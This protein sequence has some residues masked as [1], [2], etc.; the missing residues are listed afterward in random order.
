LDS[1]QLLLVL[2]SPL[3]AFSP[4]TFEAQ[5][6]YHM[7]ESSRSAEHFLA[8]GL[9]SLSHGP[10]QSIHLSLGQESVTLLGSNP[11]S[12]GHPELRLSAQWT[13]PEW[14]ALIPDL[15]ARCIFAPLP[16]FL[17]GQL[18]NGRVGWQRHDHKGSLRHLT[19][20]GTQEVPHW[21]FLEA[22]FGGSQ[23][24]S[25]GLCLRPSGG[26]RATVGPAPPWPT[27]G[28]PQRGYPW[29][30]DFRVVVD[31]D[32]PLIFRGKYHLER[33]DSQL[34]QC[35]LCLDEQGASPGVIIPVQAGVTLEPIVNVG[36]AGLYAVVSADAL[37]TDLSG[38]RVVRDPALLELAQ[39]LRAQAQ[40][41]LQ[42]LI[43]S[44]QVLPVRTLHYRPRR[45]LGWLAVCAIFESWALGGFAAVL[46]VT[47]PL[48]AFFGE[49]LTAA[50]EAHRMAPHY[51]QQ[52]AERLRARILSL[53]GE[54]S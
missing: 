50:L 31:R 28:D 18:A 49:T 27:S 24:Q 38:L 32:R 9:C 47:V 30:T 35:I 2:H 7:L 36:F 43:D 16:L 10:V 4:L 54:G 51:R 46:L 17:N 48:M 26:C 14:E 40:Q 13:C 21:H 8:V 37:H 25:S 33:F 41:A 42:M 6:E 22:F 23:P 29:T 3:Q 45:A 34:G 5:F 53:Q 39:Q 20:V 1:Q 44:P 52:Q 11:G 19:P 15:T 12:G